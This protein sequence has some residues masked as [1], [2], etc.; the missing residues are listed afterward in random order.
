MIELSNFQ[1]KTITHT[2][3]NPETGKPIDA[4][5]T[6]EIRADSS[7][8]VQEAK[9]QNR[10]QARIVSQR[11]NDDKNPMTDE[12]KIRAE[13]ELSALMGFN[14]ALAHTASISGASFEGKPIGEDKVAI[15]AVLKTNPFM[16]DQ[17]VGVG[18]SVGLF[19]SQEK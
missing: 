16:V 9:I 7:P 10:I 5:F 8:E 11:L 12:E 4:K 19:L 13:Q 2:V 6:V 18:Q 14:L 17:F 15:E 1:K 3:L